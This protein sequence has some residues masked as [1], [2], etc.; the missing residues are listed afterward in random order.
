MVKNFKSLKINEL[1]LLPKHNWKN[2]IIK[3]W[4]IGEKAAITRLNNFVDTELDGYKEG[5]NFP[6]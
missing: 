5:R 4:Q 6:H 3:S 2:K 1:N